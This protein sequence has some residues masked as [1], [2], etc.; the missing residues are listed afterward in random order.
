MTAGTPS[1]APGGL[2]DPFDPIVERFEAAFRGVLAG[3]IDLASANR[4]SFYIALRSGRD[5]AAPGRGARFR[6]ALTSYAVFLRARLRA[7][8]AAL[9]TP[10]PAP[11]KVLFLFEAE[12]PSVYETLR[13]VLDRFG[14]SDARAASPDAVPAGRRAGHEWLSLTDQLPSSAGA[15]LRGVAGALRRRQRMTPDPLLRRMSLHAWLLRMSLRTA[16]AAAGFCRLYDAFPPS[17][18]VTASDTGFWGRC[19][20]LEASLRGIPSLT[21]QHGMMVGASGYVPVLSTRIGVWGEGSAR[22][23]RDR[24]VPPE[25][26]AVTGPPR[27]D[28]ILRRPYP[29]RE[30]VARA[31]G[32]DAAARWVVLATNPIPFERNAAQLETARRGVAAWDPSARLLVKLHPSED[33]APYR[34][35]AAGDVRVVV[36]PHGAVDLYDLLKVADAVL[37]YH[38]TVGLEAMMLERP[39]VSLEAFGEPNPLPYAREGAAAQARTPEELA[40]A[41]SAD[42]EP[43]ANAPARRAARTRFLHDN[44][45]AT[46][47]KSTERVCDLIR[48]M[49]R[50][51]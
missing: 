11:A 51:G 35:A 50:R 12:N 8:A 4:L 27:L 21:L 26:I 36:V 29:S 23:L 39:V 19:A 38:S 33:P 3:G 9:P 30:T 13:G 10:R 47:G 40:A 44:L 25:K 34:A 42:V 22:W 49:A 15:A 28:E 17:V 46:D 6:S 20:T 7:S 1:G 2:A 24:G 48:S 37:T 16:R 5:F 43:G 14:P 31:L 18:L 41:L 45:A 32:L